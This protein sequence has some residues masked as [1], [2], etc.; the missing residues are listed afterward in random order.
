MKVKFT[1]EGK[2]TVPALRAE[3]LELI[4][5]DAVTGVYRLTEGNSPAELIITNYDSSTGFIKGTFQL[6]MNRL[7]V[8]PSPLLLFT[9][10]EFKGTVRRP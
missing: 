2:F 6:S 10:G 3:Y 5:G 9:A 7:G 8:N 4:G 1:G